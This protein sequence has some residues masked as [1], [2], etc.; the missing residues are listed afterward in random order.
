MHKT[1]STAEVASNT[2]VLTGEQI[3]E[4]A[5]MAGM[6]VSELTE[7]FQETEYSV[8]FSD[9]GTFGYLTDY[10]DEGSWALDEKAE[11]MQKIFEATYGNSEGSQENG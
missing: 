2:V 8:Y 1:I 10:P 11:E 4:L 7:E 6:A 3:R 9:A 5:R